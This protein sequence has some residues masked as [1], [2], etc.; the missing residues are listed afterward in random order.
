MRTAKEDIALLGQAGIWKGDRDPLM[1]AVI[2]L[3]MY[4]KGRHK[5][6]RNLH[7]L[8]NAVEKGDRRAAEKFYD[9]LAEEVSITLSKYPDIT[10]TLETISQLT[11]EDM[12]Q[13]DRVMQEYE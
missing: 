10:G 6:V 13:V 11:D 4:G 1:N 7:N 8:A 3:C 9:R 2:L 5:P 12:E